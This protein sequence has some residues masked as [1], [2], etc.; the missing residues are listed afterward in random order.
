MTHSEEVDNAPTKALR[1]HLSMKY[2]INVRSP[3]LNVVE[4]DMVKQTPQD[5]MHVILEGIAQHDIR[6][7][8]RYYICTVNSFTLRQFNQ[9]LLCY[10]FGYSEKKKQVRETFIAVYLKMVLIKYMHRCI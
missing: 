3:L 4:F 2:G 1:D 6:L 5:I 8:L 9:V 10:N 7:V